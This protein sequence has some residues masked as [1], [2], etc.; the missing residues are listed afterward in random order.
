VSTTKL[1]QK[2][3]IY[4]YKT[5]IASPV[6]TPAKPKALKVAPAFLWLGVIVAVLLVGEGFDP[7]VVVVAD[8]PETFSAMKN[9]LSA[10][11]PVV[12]SLYEA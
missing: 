10:T 12:V 9:W 5:N 1:Q 3:V 2:P 7:P 4:I 6:R 8:A 11:T